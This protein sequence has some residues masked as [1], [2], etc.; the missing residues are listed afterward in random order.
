MWGQVHNGQCAPHAGV[1][2][3][4]ELKESIDTVISNNKVRAAVR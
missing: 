2:L 1:G 4:P 3:N